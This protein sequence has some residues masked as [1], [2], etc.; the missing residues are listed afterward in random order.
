[1]TKAERREYA[2]AYR[3]KNREALNAYKRSYFAS[4]PEAREK[5]NACTKAWIERNRRRWYLYVSN[6]SYRRRNGEEN[7][8]D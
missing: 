6:Y 7:K 4:H 2:R 1:M 3:E 5:R 8:E